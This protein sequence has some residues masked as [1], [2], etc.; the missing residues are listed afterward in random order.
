MPTP[1][2]DLP[3]GLSQ[4]AVRALHAAGCDRLDAV[5]R[6]SE[7]ELLQLHGIGPNAIA[8][9]RAALSER[10]LTFAQKTRG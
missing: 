2:S 3:S 5:A 1:D 9:L 6:F 7:A 8:K 4:P 10:G